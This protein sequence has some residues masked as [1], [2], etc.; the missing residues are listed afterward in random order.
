M[1]H[2]AHTQP[3]SYTTLHDYALRYGHLQAG[4]SGVRTGSLLLA[5][6][7]VTA[8]GVT[9]EAVGPTAPAAQWLQ[10]LQLPWPKDGQDV[11]VQV[12]NL[13]WCTVM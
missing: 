10:W 13:G 12:R 1:L 5:L 4:A 2:S 9:R 3:C 7:M 6:D 8:G 11:W